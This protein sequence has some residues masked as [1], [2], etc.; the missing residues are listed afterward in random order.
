MRSSTTF[1]IFGGILLL[2]AILSMISS[3]STRSNPAVR[4]ARDFFT[5]LQSNDT[6]K[7]LSLTDTD[8]AQVT[9]A[10]G[11]VVSI[12]FKGGPLDQHGAFSRRD[13]NMLSYAE[14]SALSLK[15]NVDPVVVEDIGMAAVPLSNGAKIYLHRADKN[16]AWK[17]FYISKPEDEQKAQ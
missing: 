10:G 9:T 4:T 2:A 13:K 15:L 7:L 16:S 11:K 6:P 3:N 1:L 12:I 14:L 8:A 5:A 17:V